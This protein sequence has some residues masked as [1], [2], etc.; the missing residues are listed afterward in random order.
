MH[1]RARATSFPRRAERALAVGGTTLNKASNPRGWT[2]TTWSGT[3]SG[4][5]PYV[6]KPSWQTDTGCSMRMEGDVAAVADPGT[7]MSVYNTQ[8]GGGWGIVGGTSAASPIVA[9]SLTSL[10]IANGHFT[11]AWVWQN[12]EN[13]FDIT[14]GNNGTCTGSPSYFCTAGTGY[15]G[16]T[17]WGTPNG[18]LLKSALPPGSGVDGGA[19]C[20]TPTGSYSLSC[21]GCVV[22]IRTAGCEL[23]CQS[24]G[25]ID[26]TQNPG[27][28]L[29][30][31]CAGQVENDN[32]VLE[33]DG[34][35]VADSGTPDAGVIVE[36]GTTDASVGLPPPVHLDG[37][38][39]VA[40][41]GEPSVVDATIADDGSL[42]VEPSAPTGGASSCACVAAGAPEAPASLTGVIALGS[43]GAGWGLRRRRRAARRRLRV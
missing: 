14:T 25:K 2:E 8:G 19:T 39:V 36:A 27:P 15:D 43:V 30:L 18:N 16:P 23:T 4:C 42:E 41:G 6:A 5:S 7:G 34:T 11:P 1:I 40:E 3:G 26:G 29:A 12:G 38:L 13:F 24:C 22:G 28:V 21:T 17:G 9:G 32:G 35:P 31:P 33:C 20:A 37:G 10:G